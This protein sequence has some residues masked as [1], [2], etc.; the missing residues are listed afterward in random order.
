MRRRLTVVLES[1]ESDVIRGVSEVDL[2]PAERP[3]LDD[4]AAFL[5]VERKVRSIDVARGLPHS[6]RPPFHPSLVAH[7]G[8]EPVRLVYEERLDAGHKTSPT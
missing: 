2:L 6:G 5:P 1:V 8:V 3:A 7:L 4:D